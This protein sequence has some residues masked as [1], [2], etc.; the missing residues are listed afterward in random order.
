M[1]LHGNDWIADDDAP[2][3]R[4][5]SARPAREGRRDRSRSRGWQT[6]LERHAAERGRFAFDPRSPPHRATSAADSRDQIAER[7]S[8][9]R[10]ARS[11]R[12]DAHAC[13]SHEGET[14]IDAALGAH[15]RLWVIVQTPAGPRSARLHPRW[16]ISPPPRLRAR[17]PA[18]A[19]HP[20][21]ARHF[22]ERW[23][24]QI[25][26]L[27]ENDAAAARARRSR[28][29]KSPRPA[30]RRSWETVL[31]KSIWRGADFRRRQGPAAPAGRQTVRARKRNSS[32]A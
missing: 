23:S 24:E 1:A 13:R 31:E 2:R 32:C 9:W 20:R 18:A 17:R 27:E 12:R 14:A 16:R 25:V 30:T 22:A 29:R 15:D 11:R 26:L 28:C 7:R 4:R 21:R 3:I 8:R 19:P 6:Q 5:A 10:T